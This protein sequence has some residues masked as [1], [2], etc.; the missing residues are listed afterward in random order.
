MQKPALSTNLK[1]I[2][3]RNNRDFVGLYKFIQKR[4]DEELFAS[5]E[6]FEV[7]GESTCIAT[8]KKNKTKKEISY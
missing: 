2:I 8:E 6:H 3:I 5:C 4:N 1:T 7:G